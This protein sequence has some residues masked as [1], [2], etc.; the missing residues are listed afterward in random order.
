MTKITV[1]QA[2]RAVQ[3]ATTAEEVQSVLEQCKKDQLHEVFLA[4]TGA[5]SE[6]CPKS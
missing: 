1:N 2:V 5:E 4:V 3:S 6:L